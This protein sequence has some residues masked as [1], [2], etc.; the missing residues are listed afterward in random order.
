MTKASPI[1]KHMQ[2][3]VWKHTAKEKARR[4]P[5]LQ[6]EVKADLVVVGAGYCGLNTALH[7]A[8]NGLSV[9]L[10]EG[11]IVGNGASG[12]NGGMNVP[13]FPGG[14][15]ISGVEGAI[16]KRKGQ[17]LAQLVVGGA[18]AAFKQAAELQIKSSSVQ[19]GWLQPAHS[20]ASLQ[21]VRKVYEEWKAFG[22]P[23]E[24]R[25]AADVADLT[26]AAGYIG[27][28]INP[29]GG[30]FNPYA[31]AAGLGRSASEQGVKIFE[32]SLV[33]GVSEAGGIVTVTTDAGRVTARK[34]IIATNGYTGNFVERVQR[35]SVPVYL[36]HTVTKPLRPELR[37][38]IMK[39]QI[40]FT[41]LRKSGGFGRYDEDGRLVSGG[42]IFAFG[43]HKA[44]S[45]RHARNRMRLLFPQLKE[46]D[47][48]LEHYW[49]G[50]CAVADTFL[51]HV[52]RVT[53]NT[54]AVT[55][56]STRGVNLAQNLGRVI[57]QFA[58]G[59]CELDDI[60]VKVTEAPMDV[61]F[62]PV[63]RFGARKIFPFYQLKDRLGLT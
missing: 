34:A 17:A 8:K 37:K 48:Q 51:P 40:C 43:S 46:S 41:D 55:G 56:F 12:R 61:A 22:A 21:K 2:G 1:D 38:S 27:G 3:V 29:T 18:D 16:G 47:V 24:W 45:E 25:S 53:P 15:T 63:K 20:E 42:A 31:L 58:A 60:P 6:G 13:H 19:N 28:W 35:A 32:E 14:M 9:V 5:M 62:W 10:L 30:T 23:V 11:G 7:A 54:F 4:Y 44:Y 50:Y 57:G 52:Q 36:F 49:E 59:K 26:G 33:T 39:S